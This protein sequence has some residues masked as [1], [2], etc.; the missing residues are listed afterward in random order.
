LTIKV[1]GG[2]WL[3]AKPMAQ[4]HTSWEVSLQTMAT[5]AGSKF[6]VTMG[7]KVLLSTTGKPPSYG[8]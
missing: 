1:Q 6:E 8:L 4:Q 3:I 5:T 7:A 2:L